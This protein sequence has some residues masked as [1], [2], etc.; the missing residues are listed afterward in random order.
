MSS[1]GGKSDFGPKNPLLKDPAYVNANNLPWL[2]GVTITFHVIAWTFV[3][4]RVYT[5]VFLVKCFGRDDA[6]MICA[7]IFNCFGGMATLITAGAAYGWGRHTDTLPQWKQNGYTM[8]ML[9][10][11]VFSSITAFMFIKLSIAF[12]LLRLDDRKGW[13][14]RILY[15][16]I[17]LVICYTIVGWTS[18]ALS[19]F[20][21]A[22]YWDKRIEGTCLDRKIFDVFSYVNTVCNIFTDFCFATLPIPLIWQLKMNKKA[23]IYL[24]AIFGLGY[25]TCILGILKVVF[26]FSPDH[27]SPDRQF[28][29]W[30]RLWGL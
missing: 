5:R 11:G 14:S 24:I 21:I 7:I 26:Q 17:G 15:C 28:V 18:W 9:W 4:L 10:H 23:R 16:L 22:K 1:G 6:L 12:S 27:K 29:D 13:Y 2:L 19:C 3:C 30:V 25:C 20:P 8:M